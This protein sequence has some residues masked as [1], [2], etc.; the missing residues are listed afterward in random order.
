MSSETLDPA[1][2]PDVFRNSTIG[3]FAKHGAVFEF[4]VQLCTDLDTMPI[5]DASVQWPEAESPYVTV[6]TLTLPAQDALSPARVEY[7]EQTLAFRPAHSLVSH[8][9]LGS[10]M[11]ARLQV[12]SALSTFRHHYNRAAEAEPQTLDAVP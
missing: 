7:V 2:D 3:Y 5:E 12:Y 1:S 6:A 11:R 10:L 8:H 9:P 4:R